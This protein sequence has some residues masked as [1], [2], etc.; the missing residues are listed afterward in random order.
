MTRPAAR[1]NLEN[2]IRHLGYSYVAGTDEVGRGALAGPVVAAAVV[3]EPGQMLNG[4]RDSKLLSARQRE[5]LYAEI[6]A[7]AN[8]ATATVSAADVDLLNVHAASLMAMSQAL[9]GLVPKPDFVLVDGF[10]LPD[11]SIPQRAIVGGD[12]KCSVIAAASVIAKVT[13]DR[14][15]M[16][17]HN[18]EPRYGFDRHKGY[19]TRDHL[20]ALQRYGLTVEH[21]RSFKPVREIDA[22]RTRLRMSGTFGRVLD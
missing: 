21:R 4:L 13:R 1:R 12:R 20:E 2:S 6:I 5:R 14:L 11:L 10:L 18:A 7:C 9:S 17:I 15:L 19:G 16:D 8:W 22:G 3:L